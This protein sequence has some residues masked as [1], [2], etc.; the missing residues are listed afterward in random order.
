MTGTA[1]RSLRAGAQGWL[2][3]A[4][5]FLLAV[6]GVAALRLGWASRFL[7]LGE[8]RAWAVPRGFD[9][10]RELGR[11]LLVA[12][13]LTGLLGLALRRRDA[14]RL[15]WPL[16]LPL[17]LGLSLLSCLVPLP[18]VL[19]LLGSAPGLWLVVSGFGLLWSAWLAAQSRPAEP[20]PAELRPAEPRRAEAWLV[21]AVAAA[22]LLGLASQIPTRAWLR[23]A[24]LTG[25][26]PEYLLTCISLLDDGDVEL[27]N[28]SE[29]DAAREF[30]AGGYR[31]RLPRP[32]H[33]LGMP[34]LVAPAY[35]LGRRLSPA[36]PQQAVWVQLVLITALLASELYCLARPRGRLLA[37]FAASAVFVPPLLPMSVQIYPEMPAA[38]AA[39]LCWRRLGLAERG[40]GLPALCLAALPWLHVKYGALAAGLLA[41]AALSAPLRRLVPAFA[42]FVLS[43]AALALFNGLVY[44]SFLPTASYG[45]TATVLSTGVLKGAL[46]LIT[47]QSFG[48]LARAPVFL[49]LLPGWV[50]L[51]RRSPREAL[52]LGLVV[53][54]LFV[55]V[56]SYHLWWA[57]W[58]PPGRFLVPIVPFLLRVVLEALDP[59][60]TA[61][62]CLAGLLWTLSLAA[63]AALV[64][65]P[66]TWLGGSR[67]LMYQDPVEPSSL[68][69]LWSHGWDLCAALP[70]LVQAAPRDWALG[71]GLLI[72]CGL[73][74][75]GLLRLLRPVLRGPA[76]VTLLLAGAMLA[77]GLGLSALSELVDLAAPD[78]RYHH[79]RN[80]AIRRFLPA[81]AQPDR[82]RLVAG[83]APLLG[84]LV[85]LYEAEGLRG[86][87]LFFDETPDP[88][89]S[90]G[91]I[92]CARALDPAHAPLPLAYRYPV[93]LE[94]W[95]A[96]TYVASFRLQPPEA[97]RPDQPALALGVRA[98]F[99]ECMGRPAWVVRRE[100]ATAELDALRGK[101]GWAE[102]QLRFQLRCTTP[103]LEWVVEALGDAFCFDRVEVRAERIP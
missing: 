42:A 83:R 68:A 66:P 18:S 89:A 76:Q 60:R 92:R 87:H 62:A 101:D 41:A 4:G 53:S 51:A 88:D 37:L 71:A 52:G 32:I 31:F 70:N 85:Q 72:L 73:A 97:A 79:A 98:S 40:Q 27:K 22:L 59:P 10:P 28:N 7:D 56:A 8:V 34:L 30:G 21:F 64:P 25:D 35:A 75:L 84:Q 86:N 26:E 77:G 58:S 19:G 11:A 15:L 54:S 50:L 14:A 12:L 81:A 29:A 80:Q 102:L 82:Y 46:G 24:L 93:E 2:A 99:S 48:L 39:V 63:G 43:V 47:D 36:S 90:G 95:P 61:L 78:R 33:N 5:P 67:A 96:G 17:M 69:V 100:P 44:G 20:R 9:V 57:G 16:A 94:P 65:P 103:K 74:G 13:G 23:Q 38:T 6:A 3:A 55:V 45:R 1:E 91:T 49:A